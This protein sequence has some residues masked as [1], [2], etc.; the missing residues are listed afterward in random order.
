MLAALIIHW[1]PLT[2]CEIRHCTLNNSISGSISHQASVIVAC[3]YQNQFVASVDDHAF[4]IFA[5]TE[6]HVER[7]LNIK[8]SFLRVGF[9]VLTCVQGNQS[10]VVRQISLMHSSWWLIIPTFL[11]QS[12][13]TPLSSYR[14]SNM[15]R[16]AIISKCRRHLI[17]FLLDHQFS[18]DV[19]KIV[20]WQRVQ[21]LLLYGY[22]YIVAMS[23]C[24]IGV[25]IVSQSWRY[26]RQRLIYR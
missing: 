1:S 26:G 6:Q 24:N 18:F 12:I 21:I 5:K 4:V 16:H 22:P 3:S 13:S 7:H 15:K 10:F 25:R 9:R 20:A 19:E 8:V 14:I 23:K 11:L 17:V 2:Q